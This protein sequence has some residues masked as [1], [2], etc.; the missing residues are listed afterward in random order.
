MAAKKAVA[1][2]SN[3]ILPVT[4]RAGTVPVSQTADSVFGQ[5]MFSGTHPFGG[6]PKE[7]LG[8][9]LGGQP[10]GPQKKK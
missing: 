5:T 7:A 8:T 9:N 4:A 1:V 2:S 3:H 10:W 6:Q